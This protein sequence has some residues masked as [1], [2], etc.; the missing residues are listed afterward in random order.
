MN[1]FIYNLKQNIKRLLKNRYGSDS[2]NMFI[3][4]LSLILNLIRNRLCSFLS[5]LLL[6]TYIYRFFSRNAYQ[7]SEENRI[8]RKELKYY[9]T[10]IENI[11]THKVFKCPQCKQIIRVPRNKGRIEVTCPNCKKIID[12]RS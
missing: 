5:F 4:I 7:R 12:T 6:A 10:K 11:K 3:L 1:S 9:K 8:F 2:L